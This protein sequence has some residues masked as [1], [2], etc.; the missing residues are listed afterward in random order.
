MVGWSTLA[1]RWAVMFGY[2]LYFSARLVIMGT[3]PMVACCH[4]LIV[5]T[6]TNTAYRI[7]PRILLSN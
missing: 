3:Q 4:M 2:V 7:P 1:A 5:F 6:Y